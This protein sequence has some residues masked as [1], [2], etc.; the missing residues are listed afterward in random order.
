MAMVNSLEAV[1]KLR[2]AGMDESQAEAVVEVITCAFNGQVTKGDTSSITSEIKSE[3]EEV[4]A[5]I[6]NFK[7]GFHRALWIQGAGIV[8]IVGAFIAIATALG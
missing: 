2:E 5:A 6:S 3:F 7:T 4:K 1:R 8:A